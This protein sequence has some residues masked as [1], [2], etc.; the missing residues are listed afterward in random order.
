MSNYKFT[1]TPPND[2][3][4]SSYVTWGNGFTVDEL[5]R[6]EEYCENNLTIDYGTVGSVEQPDEYRKSKVG[7]IGNNDEIG[8]LYD[9][10]AWIV[11]QLNSQFYNYDLYGFVEDFQYTIY[12]GSEQGFY[13]WHIDCGANDVSPR[14]FSM[15]LQLSDPKDYDG[16]ELQIMVDKG[17]EIAPK[18]KGTVIAFPSFRLHRVTPVVSGTRKSIVIWVTGPAFR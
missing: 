7:W 8:W 1:P 4:T 10:M 16:G 3:N 18:E 12:D 5:A 9:R 14:K 15:V 11:R 17:P 2:R 6:I 13:D